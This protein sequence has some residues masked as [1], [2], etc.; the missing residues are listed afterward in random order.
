MSTFTTPKGTVL[1]VLD[2][3]GKAY[4]QVAHRLVWFREERP[5]WSIETEVRPREND[6]L[7]KAV[8]KDEAGRIIATAHKTE[9]A[10]GFPDFI[11]KS[12]TGAVGR[13]LGLCGFG[14]QFMADELD[15]GVRLADAPVPKPAAPQQLP[16]LPTPR[17]FTTTH[18]SEWA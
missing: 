2:L 15:E 11:E 13:A 18:K 6:C 1:P 5:S 9:T 3:H 10:K 12:E 7:S 17:G 14:T 8:I 4:L 16:P